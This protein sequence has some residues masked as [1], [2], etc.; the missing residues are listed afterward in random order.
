M[1]TTDLERTRPEETIVLPAGPVNADDPWAARP[2]TRLVGQVALVTG[3]GSGLGRA[4]SEV[5]AAAGMTV[6]VA[7]VAEAGRDTTAR[8]I[9]QAG[10]KAESVALDVADPEAVTTCVTEALAR[11][12]RIDVLINNAG[13][14]RTAPFG[15][16]EIED[17]DRI[18]AV[19][20]RGPVM[21]ARAV[22]PAMR[23]A[24]HGHI[25]NI[26][27][28]A[29]KRAWE[30]ASAYHATKWGLLG[31]SHA[32]HTEARRDGIK[33]TAMVCG[34]MRTPFLLDRFPELDPAVLQDPRTVAETI[35]FVLSLPDE[36]VIP[37]ILVL[38]M[39]ESSWP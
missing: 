4:T 17:W 7:D 9:E 38:P 24:G 3:G 13:I 37:E 18:L 34:G 10:G 5:L 35:R 21:M 6:V 15:E 23:E 20:L 16:L 28:T 33:V 2:A 1:T 25:V 19:N 14:D 26:T 31:L 39:R 27:S 29:A 30:N 8:L 12:G 11:L 22:L 36:S 32:L